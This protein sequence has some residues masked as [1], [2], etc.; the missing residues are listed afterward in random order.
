MITDPEGKVILFHHT[1]RKRYPYGL[2]GG[3]LKAGE[4]PAE[5]LRR[6]VKEESDLDIEVLSPLKIHSDTERA[7]I[8]AIYLAQLVSGEFRPSEEVDQE[9]RVTIGTI[10]D[11]IKPYQR[12]V[13]KTFFSTKDTN[14]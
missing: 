13:L 14:E 3:W 7:M 9:L 4:D 12:E 10:P 8:E 5:A 11:K 1:Y 6:E 2:P